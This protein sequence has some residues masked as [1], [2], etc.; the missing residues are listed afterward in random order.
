MV[1]NKTLITTLSPSFF[2]VTEVQI[3]FLLSIDILYNFKIAQKRHFAGV[4]G[5]IY[6]QINKIE[7]K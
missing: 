7:F 3:E 5:K 1:L 2:S 4:N 6:Q